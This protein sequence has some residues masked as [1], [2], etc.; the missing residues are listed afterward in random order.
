M[1]KPTFK[2][3][4]DVAAI[5]LANAHDRLAAARRDL[6]VARSA[7]CNAL[8]EVN[9]LQKKLDEV[10]AGLRKQSLQGTDWHRAQHESRRTEG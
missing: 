8:N 9:R 3:E 5:E 10:M 6:E 2:E 7:E 4:L 1:S